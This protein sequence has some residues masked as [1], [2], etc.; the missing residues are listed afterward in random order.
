MHALLLSWKEKEVTD[1]QKSDESEE[2]ARK[3][4]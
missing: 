2:V 3:G 1:K 4:S